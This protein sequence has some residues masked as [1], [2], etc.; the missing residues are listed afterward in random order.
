MDSVKMKYGSFEEQQADGNSIYNYVKEV[1][2]LRNQYPVLSHGTAVVETEVS[3]ENICVLRKSYE[4]EEMLLIFNIAETGN[5]VDLS[6]ITLSSEPEIGGML[7]TTNEA[8]V[9]DGDSLSMPPYSVVI[10]K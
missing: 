7:L 5:T 3:N 10:L 1:I 2:R 8:A 4:G 6:G 9:L